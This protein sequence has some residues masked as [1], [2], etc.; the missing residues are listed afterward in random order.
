MP[1][2]PPNRLQRSTRMFRARGRVWCLAL[3]LSAGV[4]QLAWSQAPEAVLEE[5]SSL[6][7]A[8]V[9]QP[10]TDLI[11]IPTAGILDY[12]GYSVKTRFFQ[13]GGVLQHFSFGVFN[14]LNL[15]ASLNVDQ[16]IG[17]QTPVRL[18]R[19]ELQVKFRFFDGDRYLP[20]LA[21]GFDGQG[22]FYD[23]PSKV[24]NERQKGMFLAGSRELFL[25]GLLMH[26]GFNISDFDTNAIF[27]FL[28]TSINLRDRIAILLEWDN[29]GAT[30][31]KSRF[32]AGLRAY[33]TPFFHLDFEVRSIGQGGNFPSGNSRGPDRIVQLKYQGN[34]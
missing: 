10:D 33:V 13:G 23:R 16:L 6:P 26:A 20:A 12:G 21:V 27:G 8:R 19:P 9:I 15:G 3:I 29:I 22:R 14:R 7:P 32:N 4:G 30:L 34:F 2:S 11:D 1:P 18:R 31:S 28:G 24:Y 25:P 17:A 5:D